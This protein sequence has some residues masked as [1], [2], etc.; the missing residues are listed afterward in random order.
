MT[1]DR[2]LGAGAALGKAIRDDLPP[3]VELDPREEE[4][5]RQAMAQADDLEALEADVRA[6]G[7]VLDGGALNPS[8]RELRQGRTA[9]GP[10]LAGID[11]PAAAST[12]VLRA[13]RAAQ[14]RW[15]RAA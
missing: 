14:R 3:H 8:V 9:L 11:L 10:L 7:H 1:T 13:E 12:T 6:R 4:L 5:L 15:K 2:R